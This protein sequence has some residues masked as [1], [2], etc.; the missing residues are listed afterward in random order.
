MAN[1]YADSIEIARHDKYKITLTDRYQPKFIH[2]YYDENGSVYTTSLLGVFR[3]ELV[4]G[5][6]MTNKEERLLATETTTEL[7]GDQV[8]G[9]YPNGDVAFLLDASILVPEGHEH[10]YQLSL[11]PL[12]SNWH[13]FALTVKK[14][15]A[16]LPYHLITDT[17]MREAGQEACGD[18]PG[19]SCRK[20]VCARESGHHQK[21]MSYGQFFTASWSTGDVV[22]FDDWGEFGIVQRCEY[23]SSPILDEAVM[24]FTCK[25]WHH[26]QVTPGG[27]VVRGNHFRSG[28]N[29]VF[30]DNTI[31]GLRNIQTGEEFHGPLANQGMIPELYRHMFPNTHEPLGQWHWPQDAVK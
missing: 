24:C 13:K 30:S 11:T 31:R 21:H 4:D 25:Y 15:G 3:T 26:Q 5:S 27:M 19:A 18:T 16:T 12:T 22:Q 7:W 8:V 29:T 9:L 20:L 28:L 1:L 14:H 23:C 2:E 6:L 17:D 10:E